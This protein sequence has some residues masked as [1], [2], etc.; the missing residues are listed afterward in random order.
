MSLNVSATVG[1]DRVDWQVERD[2]IDLAAVATSMLGP[3]VGR[4]GKRGRELWWN[5][6]LGT[7][8]DANPSFCVVPGR[9]WWHCFGCAEK[10]DAATLVMRIE[11]LSFPKAVELLAGAHPLPRTAR[12]RPVAKPVPLVQSAPMGPEALELVAEAERRLWTIEGA[13]ALAYLKGRGLAEATIRAARLGVMETGI[14]LPWFHGP[15]LTMVNVRRPEGS[16]P[17]YRA[18]R[19][20]RRGGL[21]P[22]PHVIVPGYPLIVVEGEFDALLLGQELAGLAGVL[23]L[24]G[25]S[26]RPDLT[27]RGRILPAWPRYVATDADK[28]GDGVASAWP[29]SYRRVRPPEPFGDWTEACQGGL[30][31]RRLWQDVL[32]G[33]ER[34]PSYT[35]EGLSTWRRGSSSD[36]AE[37]GIVVD[38]PDRDRMMS[39][40]ASALSKPEL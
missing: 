38:L 4:R 5:C 10:G 12:P 8:P 24:G 32:A 29:G 7:H 3:A 16:D 40:V 37:P 31:L 17:K 15:D 14:T 21:Y 39:A 25:A 35:W 34:P 1:R 27:I 28:A 20:S 19:G 30:D 23:T 22:G 36:D 18:F 6:P 13:T 9:A 2:T 11:R 33:I 26:S